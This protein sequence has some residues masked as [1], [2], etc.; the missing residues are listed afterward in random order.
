MTQPSQHSVQ[1]LSQGINKQSAIRL[2]FK[3]SLSVPKQTSHFQ[4]WS[5][6]LLNDLCSHEEREGHRKKQGCD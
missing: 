3:P 4:G 2:R 5:A 6:G 1:W